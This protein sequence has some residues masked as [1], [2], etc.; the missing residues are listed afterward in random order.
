MYPSTPELL[1]PEKLA[2]YGFVRVSSS[3]ATGRRVE[4]YVS[5]VGDCRIAS[6][7]FYPV[8]HWRASGLAIVRQQWRF[9]RTMFGNRRHIKRG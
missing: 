2:R 6:V 4:L 9:L 7:V 5:C 3:E 8:N 1:T